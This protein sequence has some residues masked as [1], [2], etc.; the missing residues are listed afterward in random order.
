M[1]AAHHSP[2]TDS[3]WL[4]TFAMTTALA[5]TGKVE[6][7]FLTAQVREF[8]RSRPAGDPLRDQVVSALKGKP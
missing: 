1:P 6:R 7:Q 4:G 3:Y 8:A 2:R 5:A